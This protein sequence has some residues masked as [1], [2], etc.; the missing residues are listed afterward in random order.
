MNIEQQVWGMTAEGQ[1]VI[2]Y[3]MTNASGAYVRLTNLGATI[4]AVGV[5]DRDGRVEDVV[6]GYKEW[7]SYQGDGAA[8]GKSVGRYANR[9]AKGR[10]VLDGTE[11]RLAINNGPNHLHG[12]PAGFANRVWESRVETDRVVFSYL[13]A[14]GEEGYPGELTVEACYDWDDECNLEI[15]YY[16]RAEAPTILN[17]TNHV[18]FNLTGDGQGDILDHTL[19]LH[20]AKFLPTDETAI[21]SGVMQPVAGTPM[22]FTEPHTIGERIHDKYQ[23]LII[24]KGYDHCWVID[25]YAKGKLSPAGVLESPATG[26]RVEVFTTQ[27][28]IQV[29]TGNWLSGSPAGKHGDYEDRSGVA[30]ECQSFPDTPNKPQFPSAVLRPGETYEQKIS[31]KFSAK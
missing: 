27:P 28:G 8:M 2:L 3:T 22:D 26:R 20:C 18:Y 25:G 21:P 14:D 6:L 13:S 5:P 4:V 17:L 31:Y 15:T 24:G 16:G 10:F 7:P 23:Q 11:Y 9:I 29:Y 19:Q 1:P 30:L 12:G